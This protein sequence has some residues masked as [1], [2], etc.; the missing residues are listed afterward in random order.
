LFP[1]TTVGSI[2]ESMRVALVIRRQP[3]NAAPAV[4]KSIGRRHQRCIPKTPV[5]ARS[6]T[7]PSLFN[8][9]NNAISKAESGHESAAGDATFGARSAGFAQFLTI[10][11]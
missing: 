5:R 4:R 10:R 6:R 3:H 11:N 7:C 1:Q 8:S 2:S 9:S